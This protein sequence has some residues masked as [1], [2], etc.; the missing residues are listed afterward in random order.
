MT[1]RR[2]LDTEILMKSHQLHRLWLD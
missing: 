1:S 2:I